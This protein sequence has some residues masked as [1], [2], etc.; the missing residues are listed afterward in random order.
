MTYNMNSEKTHTARNGITGTGLKYIALL[1]MF[2]DHFAAVLLLKILLQTTDPDTYMQWYHIYMMCRRIGR[3]AFPIFCF[4][5]VEG[6]YYTHSRTQ[7]AVRLGIFALLSELPFDLAL[8]TPPGLEFENQNVFFTLF[9]GLL[10]MML[11]EHF[12]EKK[13][14]Q[15]LSL[16]FCSFIAFVLCTDYG[17]MGV[18]LIGIFYFFRGNRHLLYPSVACWLLVGQMPQHM[19]R[20]F[21]QPDP[22]YTFSTYFE[23]VLLPNGL[24][25]FWG[26]ISLFFIANYKGQK[27]RSFPKYFFYIFYPAHLLLLWGIAHFSIICDMVLYL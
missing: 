3:I 22:Q 21:I 19:I 9:L 1:T 18:V 15:L 8:R 26:I 6:F 10:A 12:E 5:L 27:G 7:Y 23:K 20:F 14:L 25:E 13:A 11:M 17:S 24:L 2:I 16:L 4:L